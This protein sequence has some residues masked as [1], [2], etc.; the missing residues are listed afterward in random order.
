[1]I[2]S[3][4]SW[5]ISIDGVSIAFTMAKTN[6]NC[7]SYQYCL[8]NITSILNYSDNRHSNLKL[9]KFTVLQKNVL[10]LIYYTCLIHTFYLMAFIPYNIYTI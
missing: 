8:N 5:R 9:F 1:M 3:E 2:L 10:R 6:N 7:K 4:N